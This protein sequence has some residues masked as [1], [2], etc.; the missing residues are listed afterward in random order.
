ME[1]IINF[2]NA[3]LP[4]WPEKLNITEIHREFG[5]PCWIVSEEQLIKNLRLFTLFTGSAA[6]VLFPVKTNPSFSVLQVLFRNGAGAD[7]ANQSEVDLALYAGADIKNISYNSPHQDVNLCY[8]L[9]IAG[10]TVVMDD[11]DAIFELQDRLYDHSF[12][13]KLFLRINPGKQIDYTIKNDN[14]E[15]MSHAHTSS[16][17]GIPAE[18]LTAIASKIKIP[19]SGLH[20]HVGTQMDNLES[21]RLAILELNALVPE[22]NSFGH[23]I[24]GINLGGGLGIPFE[25]EDLFPS[26]ETWSEVLSP[27][28]VHNLNYFVEPG[29]ALSGNAVSLLTEVMT[30][31]NSRGKKWVIVDVGTD[32]LA[33]V[34][35]LR[36]P[37][38]IL[39]ANGSV[40][41]KGKDAIA[42]P[43]CFAGDTLLHDADSS[44]ITKGDPLLITEAGAY[45]YSLSN[46]FNGRLAPAWVL[47]KSNG[48]CIKTMDQEDRYD[49]P[50]ITDYRWNDYPDYE[51]PEKIDLTECDKLSS[52]YLRKGANQDIFTFTDIRRLSYNTFEFEFS[53]NSKVDFISMPFA[54]RIFGD[55]VI[56]AILRR[57]GHA[58]KETSVWGRKLILSSFEILP[59]SKPVKFIVSLSEVLNERSKTVLAR[60]ETTC[61]RFNGTVIAKY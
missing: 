54:I 9:I 37:H 35:L 6:R 18:E 26:I 61:G 11:P 4:D 14:Q 46:R 41:Q 47:F 1:D 43:L 33:K 40:I 24:S 22:V 16:K 21:F 29:H 57:D 31:K 39:K 15:L 3:E 50:Q 20:I 60:F 58:Q 7:C 17:F 36:W 34:T 52:E 5:S 2:K 49:N 8:H 55:A 42:G 13:G 27:L 53:A 59:A 56:I 12:S 10:A 44:E 28:K 25:P 19:V 48:V 30:I 32:Q 45:T 51:T 23:H 38:R